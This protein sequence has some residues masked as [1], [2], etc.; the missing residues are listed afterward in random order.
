ME[1]K[2]KKEIVDFKIL[3]IQGELCN[4]YGELN[5]DVLE[6]NSLY[7]QG[8]LSKRNF[9][10]LKQVGNDFHLVGIKKALVFKDRPMNKVYSE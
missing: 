9:A 3:N 8:E 5:N 4:F 10:V 7:M 6:F 2:K 1:I